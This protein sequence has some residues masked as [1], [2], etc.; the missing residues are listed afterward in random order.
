MAIGASAQTVK[1][2]AD[3]TKE[4]PELIKTQ[5]R[6]LT[7]LLSGNKSPLGLENGIDDNEILTEVE[8]REL[9]IKK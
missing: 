3:S 2:Y 9:L 6:V 5:E 4:L 7:Q 1:S 8:R